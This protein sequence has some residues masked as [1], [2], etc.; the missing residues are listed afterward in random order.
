MYNDANLGGYMIWFHPDQKVF[1]D[2]RCELYGDDWMWEYVQ[3]ITK[4]PERIEGWAD[5]WG[6]DRALVQC[7]A[8]KPLKLESYLAASPRWREVPGGRGKRAVL[9]ERV[10]EASAG[11]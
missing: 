5:R 1:M 6:F 11:R 3:A 9:F 4:H 8:K 10:P 2:D 7:D